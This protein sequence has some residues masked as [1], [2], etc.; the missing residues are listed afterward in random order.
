MLVFDEY[1]EDSEIGSGR[2]LRQAHQWGSMSAWAH[3]RDAGISWRRE[4][5][6]TPWRGRGVRKGDQDYDNNYQESAI[7]HENDYYDY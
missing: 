7:I 2:H 5:A 4:I 6:R 1:A 3:V